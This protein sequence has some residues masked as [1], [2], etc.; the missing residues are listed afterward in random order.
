[1]LRRNTTPPRTAFRRRRNKAHVTIGTS[2]I[3]GLPQGMMKQ[4]PAAEAL[5]G[6]RRVRTVQV[7]CTARRRS[8]PHVMLCSSSASLGLPQAHSSARSVGGF[9][10][11]RRLVSNRKSC[12]PSPHRLPL[13]CPRALRDT[14]FL[15]FSLKVCAVCCTWI[16][17]YWLGSTAEAQV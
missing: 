13:R 6:R 1:M 16:A 3:F 4:A 14:A 10:A 12:P 5:R 2:A 7:R 17:A 11:T 15:A 9:G 8:P